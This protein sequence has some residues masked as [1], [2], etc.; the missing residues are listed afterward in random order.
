[1]R[2]ERSDPV[3]ITG[4]EQLGIGVHQILDLTGSVSHRPSLLVA[5]ALIGRRQPAWICHV[6]GL[7]QLRGS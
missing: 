6:N 3:E 2:E 7:A 5:R 1:V 4:I